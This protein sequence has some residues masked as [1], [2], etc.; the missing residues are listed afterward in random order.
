M[1]FRKVL[2][3]IP[4]RIRAIAPLAGSCLLL[5][6]WAV[7]GWTMRPGLWALVVILFPH[8][9]GFHLLRHAPPAT[10]SC[11]QC[12]SPVTTDQRFCSSC[13]TSLLTDLA[14]HPTASPNKGGTR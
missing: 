5:A 11:T 2:S 6:G 14:I 13:G 4:R 3:V 9:L 10:S 12:S 8:L 1:T 7:A